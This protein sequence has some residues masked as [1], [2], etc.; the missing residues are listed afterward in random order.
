MSV[1]MK[2][3]EMIAG[4]VPK[5]E[6]SSI[7]TSGLTYTNCTYV[8]GGY[9][10]IGNVV[11]V[12]IRVKV[13]EDGHIG[14]NNFPRPKTIN[15]KSTV[16]V[17]VFRIQQDKASQ[18]YAYMMLVSQTTAHILTKDVTLTAG[19]EYSFSAVYVSDYVS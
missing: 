1:L 18:L 17:N 14:I 8:D 2:N 6:S 9:S 10:V 11:I 5:D 3:E 13:T 16:G 12:N 15:N 19:E 4:V 7:I